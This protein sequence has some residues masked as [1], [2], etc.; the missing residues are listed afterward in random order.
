MDW[1]DPTGL[2]RSDE[3]G[4]T[5]LEAVTGAGLT[6]AATHSRPNAFVC[7][8]GRTY[9]VKADVQQG[10]VAELIA[11]RLA[12]AVGAGPIAR[13][14]RVTKGAVPADR[15]TD[16]LLGVVVGSTDQHGMVNARDLA[17]L[18]SSGQFQAGLI[19]P[20]WRARVV[21]FHTWL[22]MGDAQVLVSLTDGKVLSIDHGDCFGDLQEPAQTPGPPV[23]VDIPGVPAEVGREAR[24]VI[25]AVERIEGVSDAV[26]LDA[27]ARVPAGDEWRGPTDRRLA[28]G[29]W[30][31]QRRQNI[32]GVMAAW[33]TT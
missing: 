6:R 22:G 17:P 20:A 5:V 18:M 2:L 11:G 24:Y 7:V 32:R 8:D 15:S 13:I 3:G 23:V 26:L 31:A 16:H 28:I 29:R 25:P 27:I 33:M 4:Y 14:I 10:L 12:D 1:H 9:W 19:D 21:V 30:L